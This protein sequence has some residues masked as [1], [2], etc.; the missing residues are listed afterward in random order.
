[1]EG[2]PPRALSPLYGA[3]SLPVRLKLLPGHRVKVAAQR[4]GLASV[5][6][7]YTPTWLEGAGLSM[8]PADCSEAL[9]V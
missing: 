6:N 5:Q 4:L 8:V 7:M 2:P 3:Q 9:K 1:M